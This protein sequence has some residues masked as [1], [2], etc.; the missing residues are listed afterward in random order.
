MASWEFAA[1]GPIEAEISLPS[2]HVHLTAAQT[3]TVTV[4]LLPEQKRGNGAAEKLIAETEV[5]F[6][7]GTLAVTVPKRVQLRGGAALDLTVELPEG[8]CVAAHTA[9]ADV[10]CTGQLGSLDGHTAS[11]DVTAD[12]ISGPANLTTASGDVRLEEAA[13]EVMIHTASGD[14][15][16]GR[17]GGDITAETASGSV[18]IGRAG[19]SAQVKTASGDVQIDSVLSGR[20][21]VTTVSGDITVAVPPGI[22]VYLDISAV[23]GHVS[24]ELDADAQGS[25]GQDA[26]L[27]VCCRSVSGDVRITRASPGATR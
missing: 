12:L 16:I 19:Q 13:G 1:T 21:D 26:S 15:R 20:A 24:S 9:S 8:S 6:E 10:H 27:T 7:N 23:S 2:G 17:A 22:G 14:T 5:S 25:G 3:E 4:S 11:G 18:A